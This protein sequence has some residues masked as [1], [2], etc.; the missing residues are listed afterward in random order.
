MAKVDVRYAYAKL[1][2]TTQIL[3]THPG[4]IKERLTE[5][6]NRGGWAMF[7]PKALEVEDMDGDAPGFYRRVEKAITTA[8]RDEKLGVYGPS[9]DRLSEQEACDVAQSLIS[10]ESMMSFYLAHRKD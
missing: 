6:I 9:I 3:A 10:L 5:A 8:P 1:G 2:E 4:R 7:D